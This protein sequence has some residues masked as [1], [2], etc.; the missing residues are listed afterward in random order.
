VIETIRFPVRGMTC[1]SCVGHIVKA[2]RKLDGVEGI[3]IDLGSEVATVRLDPALVSN[4]ALA[5]AVSVAGYEA[6]LQAA[7]RVDSDG[8]RSLLKRLVGRR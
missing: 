3:K 2:V 4:D 6:D 1:A 8:N 7:V 5:I